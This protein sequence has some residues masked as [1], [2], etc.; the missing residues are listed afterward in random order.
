MTSTTERPAVPVPAGEGGKPSWWDR[1]GDLR[2][3]LGGE[4]RSVRA[5]RGYEGQARKR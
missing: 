1:Q 3:K 4:R 2:S 5:L